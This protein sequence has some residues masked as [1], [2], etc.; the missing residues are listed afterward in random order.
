MVDE[1]NLPKG[2][3]PLYLRQIDGNGKEEDLYDISSGK[4]IKKWSKKNKGK[5]RLKERLRI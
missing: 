5:K 2:E 4:I 3:V 1:F